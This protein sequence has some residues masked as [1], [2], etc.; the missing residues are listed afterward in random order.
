MTRRELLAA[1]AVSP[2]VPAVVAKAVPAAAAQTWYA[3]SSHHVF[4]ITDNAALRYFSRP[5]P[6]LGYYSVRSNMRIGDM[7]TLRKPMTRFVAH[8]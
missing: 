1:L 7:L 2:F 3:T 5:H 4:L 6:E 8:A